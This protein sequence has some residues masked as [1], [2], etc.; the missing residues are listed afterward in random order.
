M[1]KKTNKNWNTNPIKFTEKER[2]KQK[3]HEYELAHKEKRHNS[4]MKLKK[5]KLP[6][7]TIEECRKRRKKEWESFLKSYDKVKSHQIIN[8]RF[9]KPH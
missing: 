7:E 3:D 1:F 6:N 2:K 8:P 4:Y 5:E 9:G